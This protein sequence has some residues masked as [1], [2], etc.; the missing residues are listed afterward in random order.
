[1]DSPLPTTTAIL[2]GVYL[3]SGSTGAQL[4]TKR[5]A[6]NFPCIF[7]EKYFTGFALVK[8]NVGYVIKL[9]VHN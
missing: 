7:N 3:C 6:L 2:L 4:Y 1:M 5:A 8:E 9:S